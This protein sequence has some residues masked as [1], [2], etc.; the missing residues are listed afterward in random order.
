MGSA[1]ATLVVLLAPP[2]PLAGVRDALHDWSALGLTRS[3]VWVEGTEATSGRTPGTLIEGGEVS[4]VTLEQRLASTSYDRIRICVLVPALKDVVSVSADL[5]DAVADLAQARGGAAAVD[6]IRCTIT[7]PDSGPGHGQPAREGWHNLVISPEDSTGPGRG[8]QLLDPSL[9]AVDIGAHAAAAVSGVAGLWSGITGAPL[10][11]L[12]PD[13]GETVR[14][15]RCFYR[16]LDA[17]DVEARL[18]RGVLSMGNGLPRP[19]SGGTRSVYVD[20][21]QLATSDLAK[22]FWRKHGGVLRSAR[23]EMPP[24]TV[25]DLG[26]GE[27]LRML[28]GFLWA[29]IKNAPAA[30]YHRVIYAFANAA[31]VGLQKMIYGEAPSA[32]NVLVKG[33]RG[34]GEPADWRDI[35]D[36]STQLGDVVATGGQR[37]LHVGRENLGAVWQDFV[38]TAFTLA[39]A[40]THVPDVPPVQI[41]IDRGVLRRPADVA[42]GRGEAF[43]AIPVFLTDATG[44]SE[45]RPAD[46]LGTSIVQRRLERLAQ[47]AET[48]LDEDRTREAIESWASGHRQSFVVQTA[49]ILGHSIVSNAAEVRRLLEE[50]A[51]AASQPVVDPEAERRQQRLA[52]VMRVLLGVFVVAVGVITVL[53]VRGTI[54]PRTAWLSGLSALVLWFGSTFAVFFTQQRALFAERHRRRLAASQAEINAKNLSYALQDLRR[55]TQA[56]GQLLA[57]SRVVSVLVARP[58]GDPPETG[59][60]AEMVDEGMPLSTRLGVA[61]PGDDVVERAV[62]QLRRDHYRFGWLS[63]MWDQVL[64]D[65]ARRLGP[66]ALD[67]A[68]EPTRMYAEPGGDDDFLV[69][70]ADLLESEGPGEAAARVWWSSVVDDVDSDDLASALVADVRVTTRGDVGDVEQFLAGVGTA[71]SGGQQLDR[72]VFSPN[73]RVAGAAAITE[74]WS[75]QVDVGGLGKAWVTVQFSAGMPAYELAWAPEATT[76]SRTSTIPPIRVDQTF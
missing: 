70:W 15:V 11:G 6:R 34:D 72:E 36:A 47:R 7:R 63:P 65:A 52:T 60:A 59:S 10:D 38:G 3:F 22:A 19:R 57:W 4:P 40:G 27:A 73:A 68:E 71:P 33:V 54:E 41:N 21:V 30:W 45:L 58:F 23:A 5:E 20:D 39:D 75:R 24:P 37:A 74:T 26:Q 8:H 28:F 16:R 14:V 56:Y 61:T 76:G 46:V 32:Y 43:T 48:S 1:A 29:V 69:R 13:P 55:T 51:S 18:R 42:P 2:G 50:L 35:A 62:S 17:G 12:R 66:E 9:D 64:G 25:K 49:E 31:A 53:G 44:Y 67:L